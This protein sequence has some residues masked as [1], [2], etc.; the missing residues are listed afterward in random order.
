[1]SRRPGADLKSA[2]TSIQEEKSQMGRV[3]R[4]VVLLALIAYVVGRFTPNFQFPPAAEH[5][6]HQGTR[7]RIESHRGRVSGRMLSP[8]EPRHI[9]RL[10]RGRRCA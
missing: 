7:A 2:L 1:M 9:P 3:L 10:R 8:F 5:Y 4:L 6:I